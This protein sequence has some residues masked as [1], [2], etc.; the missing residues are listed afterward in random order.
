[1]VEID[2][3]SEKKR[4]AKGVENL[5]RELF[6][7]SARDIAALPCAEMIKDEIANGRCLRGGAR[8]RQIKHV[9]RMLRQEEEVCRGLLNLLESR[10][11][12]KL[13]EAGEFHQLERLRNGII[14]DAIVAAGGQL[15][16]GRIKQTPGRP[17]GDDAGGTIQ[18]ALHLLP[19]LSAVELR[20]AAARY[21]RTRKPV[22]SRELFRLLKAALERK[23]YSGVE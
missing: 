14:N 4:R 5:A 20:Q 8:K 10:K 22:Y 3:R 1:V 17:D 18:E 6:T 19:D 16:A 13:K 23:K 12:S 9:A 2:S 7:L 15:A 21:A 11:G